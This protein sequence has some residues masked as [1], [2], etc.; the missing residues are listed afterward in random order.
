MANSSARRCIAVMAKEPRA[1]LVK[2]RLAADLGDVAAAEM[3]EAFLRDT[4]EHLPPADG[5][6]RVLYYSPAEAEGYFRALDAKAT[7][8]AQPEVPFG[9]RLRLGFEQLFAAGHERVLFI[10]CDTPHLTT[11]TIEQ[12]FRA[13]ETGDVV[14]GP[15]ADGGYYLIG[16]RAPQPAL[17]DDVPWSSPQVLPTTRAR[18]AQLGLQLHELDEMFDVDEIADLRRLGE[19][20]AG[21]P[22]LCPATLKQL[23]IED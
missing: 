5:V 9:E 16:L 7:C 11:A 18:A 3:C 8:L 15:C 13:L 6:T 23:E 17:F 19:L 4:L 14:L 12:A 21:Q 20:L 2:T 22:K 1:G 10:G